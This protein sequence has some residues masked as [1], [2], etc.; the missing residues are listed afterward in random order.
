MSE[1]PY[2]KLFQVHELWHS[3]IGHF[4]VL[5]YHSHLVLFSECNKISP[6]RSM[7]SVKVNE[8]LNFCG[9][10]LLQPTDSGKSGF[11]KTVGDKCYVVNQSLTNS[12][13]RSSAT[14]G[15]RSSAT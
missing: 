4:L 5:F 8:N 9:F 6:G 15:L 3:K 2:P 7:V 11:L 13:L 1:T 14:F 12:R 10:A